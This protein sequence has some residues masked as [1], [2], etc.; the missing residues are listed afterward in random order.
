MKGF[1]RRVL[2]VGSAGTFAGLVVPALA[3]RGAHVR[4]LVR[5]WR[6]VLDTGVR[7]YFDELHKE[8]QAA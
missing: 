4:G 2:A 8:G 6:T 5:S 1:T 7:A 3:E